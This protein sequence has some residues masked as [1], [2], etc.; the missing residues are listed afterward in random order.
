MQLGNGGEVTKFLQQ[1]EPAVLASPDVQFAVHVW[2]ALKTDNFAR[3][4]RLLRR[5]SYLQA[6]LMHRYVGQVRLAGLAQ[7]MRS[8]KGSAGGAGADAYY[9]LGDL[10]RVMMFD[11]LADAEA[12]VDHC[13]FEV[14]VAE[15]DGDE[16]PCVVFTGA[17]RDLSDM[18][19]VDK[20]GHP[21]PPAVRPMPQVMMH[22]SCSFLNLAS[23]YSTVIPR[24]RP[25]PHPPPLPPPPPPHS[26]P[27]SRLHRASN[28]SD[29]RAA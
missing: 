16:G 2:C 9:P 29:C 25:P 3:F 4:F 24:A 5:A 15:G 23:I 1:L 28:P 13:G 27:P 19:P 11:D 18:L 21:I 6:C 14:A 10:Q 22:V 12:F 17:N 26:S 8:F 20:N 7:M